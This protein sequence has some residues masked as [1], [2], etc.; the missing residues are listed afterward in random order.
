M[1]FLGL[2]ART[3][4]NTISFLEFGLD[5]DQ[6]W[7]ACLS[8]L[9][10]GTFVKKYV[11]KF[12]LEA[13]ELWNSFK[14]WDS[15]SEMFKKA[16]FRKLFQALADTLGCTISI[17]TLVNNKSLEG[18]ELNKVSNSMRNYVP[19]GK[20]TEATELSKWSI[21]HIFDENL[22]KNGFIPPPEGIYSIVYRVDSKK[23]Y[24]ELRQD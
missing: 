1:I 13:M 20:A 6:N 24:F 23:C 22:E 3:H 19:I 9:V 21:V 2:I 16:L 4:F 12:K 18:S 14:N 7:S 17:V 15:K 5:F 11:E 10:R 8:I